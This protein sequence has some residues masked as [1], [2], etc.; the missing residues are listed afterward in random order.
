MHGL[1]LLM[2]QSFT[3]P[4]DNLKIYLMFSFW[5]ALIIFVSACKK[6]EE[7]GW[8]QYD[9]TQC[10]DVW[11][12]EVVSGSTEQLA[13][14]EYLIG[15][16]IEINQVDIRQAPRQFVTCEACTCTSGDV[17]RVKLR[18]KKEDAEAIIALGFRGM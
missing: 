10:A 15:V 1:Y 12:D 13:V 5:I 6:T 14:Q 16:G 2:K 11:D 8:Y 4:M 7:K 17:I 3:Q 9:G 18:N